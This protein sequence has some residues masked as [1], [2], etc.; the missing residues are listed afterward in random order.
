MKPIEKIENYKRV[1]SRSLENQE[2]NVIAASNSLRNSQGEKNNILIWEQE[3][4]SPVQPS[5]VL[6]KKSKKVKT[7]REKKQSFQH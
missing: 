3:Q 6:I 2:N 1:S 5:Q 4:G 7:D